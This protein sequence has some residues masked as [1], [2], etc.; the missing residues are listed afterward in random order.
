MSPTLPTP[1]PLLPAAT[2]PLLEVDG[3]AKEFVIHHLARR[4]PA[5]HGVCFTLAPGKFLRLHGPNGAGKSTVLRCLYR[6]YKAS[7]GRILYT[8]RAGRIDLACA[9]DVDVVWLRRHEIAFVTQFLQPRP[10]VAAL[11]MVAEPLRGVGLTPAEAEGRA[12]ELLHRL[13]LRRA[14]WGAYPATFSGGEQQKVN[15]AAGLAVPR[16]LVLVDEPTASLDPE[17]RRALVRELAGLKAG[18]TALIGVFHHAADLAELLDETLELAPVAGA[19]GAGDE[20]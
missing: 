16:R 17:A 11:E 18:G 13:G 2:S 15:L 14:L 3:L 20:P 12:G 7:A 8:S 5:L 6:T 4:I 19:D 9:A 10:R 1:D